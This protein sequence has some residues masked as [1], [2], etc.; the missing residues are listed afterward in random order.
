MI[1]EVVWEPLSESRHDADRCVARLRKEVPELQYRILSGLKGW[2]IHAKGPWQ[3]DAE[4]IVEDD[5]VRARQ[6]LMT[7]AKWFAKGFLASA[8]FWER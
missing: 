7:R 2:E 6:M 1:A 3:D 4:G 5:A 8:H